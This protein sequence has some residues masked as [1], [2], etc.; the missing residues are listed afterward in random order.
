MNKIEYLNVVRC[1]NCNDK[2]VTILKGEIHAVT[3]KCDECR[4][5][6]TKEYK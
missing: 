4:A 3:Y 5:I 1:P 6:F 2:Y